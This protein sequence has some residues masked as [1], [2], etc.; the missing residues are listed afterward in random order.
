MLFPRS[1]VYGTLHRSEK[2][3]LQSPPILFCKHLDNPHCTCVTLGW[4]LYCPHN[5]WLEWD[6]ACLELD[7]IVAHE[8]EW[9]VQEASNF[10]ELQ[11]RGPDAH[12]GS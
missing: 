9:K 2:C 12:G 5:G 8:G 11:W 10:N 3:T 7:R 6:D 4:C 1:A